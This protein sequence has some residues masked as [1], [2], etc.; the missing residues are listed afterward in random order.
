MEKIEDHFD[1]KDNQKQKSDRR[2]PFK[3]SMT[4]LKVGDVVTFAPRNI[5][6]KIA[7]D[8]TVEYKGEQYALSRFCKVFMPSENSENKEYQGPAHFTLNG[9]TLDDIRK[10][11]EGGNPKAKSVSNSRSLQLDFWTRFRDKLNSTGKIASLQTPQPH[12]WYDVRIGRSN[13]M[14]SDVCNTQE[15]FVG[16]KLYIRNKVA[17][18]YYPALVAR[19]NEIN[20]AL[21]CEPV[22]DANPKAKDKTVA[23][24]HQTELTDPVKL[25]KA[26]DWLVKQT[27]IFYRVFSE[28]VKRITF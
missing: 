25:E 5:Q 8:K 4:G 20:K 7:S 9:K 18:V 19:R 6:V 22:W 24:Y 1:N 26:L 10:E 14:L 28:E 21:G 15:N 3:F 16:V 2:A 23:L 11:R 27:L 17:D 13:I 12:Y